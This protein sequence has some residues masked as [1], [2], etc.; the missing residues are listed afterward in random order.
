MPQEDTHG[1]VPAGTVNW[2]LTVLV[3]E[4]TVQLP[5]NGEVPGTTRYTPIFWLGLRVVV[6]VAVVP[7]TDMAVTLADVPPEVNEVPLRFWK[8]E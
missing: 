8:T 7:D 2:K 3:D 6:A 4:V 1:E 5:S